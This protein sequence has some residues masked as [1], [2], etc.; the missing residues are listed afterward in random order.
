MTSATF[1]ARVLFRTSRAFWRGDPLVPRKTSLLTLAVRLLACS[2]LFGTFGYAQ[3]PTSTA[4]TAAPNPASFGQTVTLQATVTTGATGKVTFYDGF[5]VLGVGTISGTH[6]SLTTTFLPVGTRSLHARYDGDSTYAASISTAVGLPVTAG[7][8]LGF[9]RGV[10]YATSSQ[11]ISLVAAD[12]NGDGKQDFAMTTGTTVQVLL[13]NGNGTFQAPVSYSIVSNARSVVSADFNGDGFADLAVSNY[14]N[15]LVYVLLGKGDGT[16]Q[17]PVSYPAN[18]S[19]QTLIT[20]DFNGDGNADIVATGTNT[21]SVW[22]LLGK[23][24]GTF[25]AP[26]SSAAPYNQSSAAVVDINADGKAD[27]ITCGNS[28]VSVLL[29]KG[30]GTFQSAVTYAVTNA[31]ALAV[32]DFNGDGYLDVATASYNQV[33]ILL[34]T[35]S[36][37][38]QSPTYLTASYYAYGISAGDFNGDGKIDLAVE[39]SYSSYGGNSLQ[40]FIGNGDG[41]FQS[42]V[43]Y[44]GA[45]AFT[46]AVVA[47]WNGDGISDLGAF[48]YTNSAG[49]AVLYFGGAIPDLTITQT[50]GSGFT[51]GQAGAAYTITVTNAGDVAT[52]GAVGVVE[53]LPSGFTATSISGDGW[54]CVLATAVCTRLDSLAPQASYPSIK[55]VVN[56]SSGLLGNVTSTATVT[57]GGDQ[58]AANNSAADT[59][60]VRHISSI[61]LNVSPNPAQLGQAVTITAS[62][63]SAAT[64]KVTFYDGTTVLGIGT[65]SGGQVAFVTTLLPSGTRYLHAEYNGDSN[66][67]PLSS[68]NWLE[69]VYINS[70]NGFRQP[71]NYRLPSS[72]QATKVVDL[73]NDGKQD[74]VTVLNGGISVQMGNGDGT[75][76][77]AVFYAAHSGYNGPSFVVGDFNGDGKPDVAYCDGGIYMLLGNGD[78]TFQTANNLTGTS[79]GY[80]SLATGDVDGDGRQDLV[81]QYGG[82]PTVLLGNGDGTI[83]AP[84]TVSTGST[85]LNSFILSDLNADGKLDLVGYTYS[86]VAV[87]IGNGDGTFQPLVAYTT[88]NSTNA[89][90]A[91]DFNGDGKLDV[92]TLSYYGLAFLAGVGDGTLRSQVN[93]NVNGTLGYQGIAVDL[94]GDGK[95]DIVAAGYYYN[96]IYFIRGNGDGTFQVPI[97]IATDS[98]NQTIAAGD[99]NGDGRIDLGVANANSSTMN[100]FLGGQFSGLAVSL[101]HRGNFIASKT[102]TYQLTVNNPLLAPTAGAVTVTATLP[103]GL[104][105]TAIDGSYYWTCTLSTLTCT[106]TYTIQSGATFQPVTITVNIASNLSPSTLTSRATVTSGG[107]QNATTDPTNIVLPTSTALAS[108][109]NPSL[110]GQSVAIVATVTSGATGSVEFYDSGSFLAT[111][112]VNNGQ[113]AITTRLLGAGKRQLK[114]TYS[115]DSTHG[116][117]TSTAT[118]QTVNAGQ[119]TGLGAVVNVAVGTS[120]WAITQGDFNGDGKTDLAVA[121]YGSNT[122]SVL[123][124]N[125]NGTFQSA[126]D[127]AVG[128]GPRGVVAGDFNNDGKMDLAAASQGSNT[129]SVLLGNG[130]GTFR[131]ALNYSTGQQPTSI[132]TGDINGDGILDVVTANS[133]NG[134]LSVFFGKG[135]GT[136]V[137]PIQTT[138]ANSANQVALSD[139]NGDG[140][141]D[142]FYGPYGYVLLGNG[143][144]TFQSLYYGGQSGPFTL[145]DLNG[146]GKIDYISQNYSSVYVGLGNGD[147]TFVTFGGYSYGNTSG[148]G[149]AVGDVNGDGKLDVLTANTSGSTISVLPG[150]GDGTLQAPQ[151][152]TV[153]SAPRGILVGD[154]NGDGRTDVAVVNSSSNAVSILLGVLT[155]VLSVTSSHSQSFA[156]GQTGAAYS[157]TVSSNGPGIT[158]GLVTVTDTLPS[159]LTAT[160]MTGQGWSCTLSSLT[161]TRSD[162]LAASA[163]YPAIALTVSVSQNAPSSVTNLVTVSGGSAIGAT[164]GDPTNITPVVLNITSGHVGTFTRGQLGASYLLS[165]TYAAGSVATSGAVTVTETLPAGLSLVSMSGS[166]WICPSGA[167]TCTRGDSLGPVSPLAYPQITVSVNVASDAASTVTNQANVTAANAGT[168]TAT[169]ATTVVSPTLSITKTADAAVVQAGSP[170]GFTIAVQN[171]LTTASNVTVTDPLPAGN[172]FN[173]SINQ[174]YSAP[175]YCAITGPAGN[176]VLGCTLGVLTPGM[177]ESVHIISNTSTLACGTYT[178]TATLASNASSL[179]SSATTTVQ[180][181]NIAVGKTA[182][183]SST[184]PGYPASLAIDGNT[185]GNVSAGSVT[186]TNG[187]DSYP[188][189][190]VDLGYSALINSIS[191]WNRTDCCATRLADYWV[192]VSDTPFSSTD[193]PSTLQGRAGTWNSHQTLVPNPVS[194]L[195]GNMQG[196]YVRVQLSG[197][198]YLSL[199][200]VQIFGAAVSANYTISGQITFSGTSTGASGVALTLSGTSSA[201]T[202]TTSSGNYSFSGLA[203][204]GN[205]TV[206]PALSGYAFNP[207]SQSVAS[208]SSG[209]VLNFVALAL[210]SGSDLAFGKT[211]SQSS[212]YPGYPAY[213]ATDGNTDGIVGHNSLTITA[214]TD[215]TPWWQVDLGASVSISSLV[216]WNRTDCC[217]S[218]L[219]DYWVFASDTPFGANDTPAILQNRSGT[220]SSHQTVMPNPFSSLT[221]G[222]QGRYVR[223]QLSSPNYLS[224]AEVQ[225]FGTV[226]A[227]STYSIS[228][229]VTLLGAGLGSVNLALSGST[230]AA[231]TTD[232]SGNFVFSGLTSGGNYAITPS[233]AGFTFSPASFI[234][235]NLTANQVANMAASGVTGTVVSAGK[236]ATQSSTYPGYPA[237]LAV[238]N[239]TDGNAG[240]GSVSITGGSDAYP[241]W[242]VDLGSSSTVNWVSIYNR[243]DCCSSRLSDY[244]LFISDTPFSANDTPATLQNRSGT[245]AAHLTTTP[246]YSSAIPIGGWPGRYV[247]IQL[248]ATGYLSLAEVQVIGTVGAPATYSVAGQVTL[249]SGGLQGVLMAV[250]GS[251][252]TQVLT[253]ASGN[254]HLGGLPFGGNYTLTPTLGGYTFAPVSFQMTALAADQTANFVATPIS[255]GGSNLAAGKSASQSSTYPGYP[256][257]LAVDGNTDGVVSHSSVTVT[258]GTDTYPWW[259][260]DLGSSASV[261]SIS[262]WNRTDCCGS[263]LGDYWVFVS[264]TP[265]SAADTPA[266]LQGRAGTWSSHQT[267]APSPSTSIPASGAQGRYVRVQLSSANY[268]SLA[269]VQVFGG[270]GPATYSITGQITALSAGLAGATLSLSGSA[271]SSTTTDA[272]GN[273]SFTGVAG[274]GNYILTPSLA[275]YTFQPANYVLTN[276]GAN[277]TAN[278]VATS[279]S[280]GSN[281]AQGKTA[282]Q[283]STYP[284]YPASLAVDGSTDGVVSHGSVTVSGG[285]DAYPWWEVDLGSSATVDSVAVWNRTDCCGSRLGDYWVFVSNTPF[286]DA[287]TPATLQNRAGTWNTH[288]TTA[289]NPSSTLSTGGV[290]GRYVRVQ[291][292]APNYLSLAEVQVIGH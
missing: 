60:F 253:D 14:S 76:S 104:T 275:G 216:V 64:G 85:T 242:Q 178:N 172:G 111:A 36:G 244:W 153:G 41:T 181:P 231:S 8:S 235:N 201:T 119:S 147:G 120:P 122:V 248:S 166:G 97:S 218:R 198:N 48:G 167:A 47:D 1:E 12:F 194:T 157:I 17:N 236:V 158:S 21:Y 288:Q 80:S 171:T 90:F 95:L 168:S 206:T 226:A 182:S 210:N 92:V 152:Y 276:L 146:D 285:S 187:T 13:G 266:T 261:S 246:T 230:T 127:Y 129:F 144:G 139:F 232:S 135:D 42:L 219:A 284:G 287:D 35:S 83:Q 93:S 240:D 65:I 186:V 271:T 126:V 184:Y 212:T 196:R 156:L 221:V 162:S 27:L 174:D 84:L 155:P 197:A 58:N 208:L 79:N 29:G 254:Y 6:A 159:G 108:S 4:L 37:T 142:L 217:G 173:W 164:G 62:V 101:T 16:F 255:S 20:G 130:D 256:A 190:Q 233:A 180:C 189:W 215:T 46:G 87:L 258:A 50:H 279:G 71:G 128:T 291:L 154:F 67:G 274:G 207:A 185:N 121:N 55:V 88:S 213:L 179:Q 250:T 252:G 238:D 138:Y 34:G 278:F 134:D 24:D 72:P 269:E 98:Y 45:M 115:G 28:S 49:G 123:L 202:N 222:A 40:V 251:V 264:D 175:G 18:V 224:L 249:N 292:S 193:T 94:D 124:G 66:Y 100:V 289:P 81:A 39:N 89:I 74:L 192:F 170:I 118:V 281:L 77:A 33:G 140:K 143:D 262:V 22:V 132:T 9:K 82:A 112:A 214:G 227:P 70:I 199:A 273:Y 38:F 44:T 241:W 200:E 91:G 10:T 86:S 203:G 165:V 268:L 247:R 177:S 68:A 225:V 148:N 211:A 109:P 136:F 110:L 43:N 106:T 52:S 7:A 228:G 237:S 19:S 2:A 263:R 63:T 151:S 163:S 54:N 150:N 286:S 103:A 191:I 272:S 277:Q 204:G 32:A 141:A 137:I 125:G 73:N 30:D 59:A 223:V 61:N 245:Y 169:D 188:W 195:Y 15:G 257:S 57:G 116:P 114:A 280:S 53:S 56:I 131:A 96:Y 209:Q 290:P 117:S 26:V 260:V 25:A 243:S 259:Q 107:I 183:Q 69:T 229:R 220:W 160:A 133:Y 3:T 145:E 78:G 283:S 105:A 102:G 161:C 11:A 31:T 149:V 282:T 267:T 234:F 239:N 205:Y 176:Q 51:Q 75:F 265:F 23:G 270:S 113:A 5:T 99:F